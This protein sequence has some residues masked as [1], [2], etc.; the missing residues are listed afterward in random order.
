MPK[1]RRDKVVAL[2]QTKKKGR[3]WKGGLIESV[4]EALEDYDSVFV[5][6]CQNQRNNTFKEM[7]KDL[8]ETSRFFMAGLYKLNSVARKRLVSTRESYNALSWF[9]A[10]ACKRNVYH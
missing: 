9:Q 3:D 8:D 10:F 5:F 1:S 2:T 7:K 6:R 4:R